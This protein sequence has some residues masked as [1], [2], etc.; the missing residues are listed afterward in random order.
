MEK[1]MLKSIFG[2]KSWYKSMTA[3]GTIGLTTAFTIVPAIAESGIVTSETGATITEWLAKISVILGIL[4]IR[5]AA[6]T[7]N[8][9]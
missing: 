2:N 9:T 4:G 1:Q 6:T 7:K 8:V 5:K 3:W